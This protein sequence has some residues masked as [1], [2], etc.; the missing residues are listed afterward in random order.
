MQKEVETVDITD[1]PELLRLAEEVQQS[2][3]PRLLTRGQEELALLSPVEPH[4]KPAKPPRR[5]GSAVSSNNDWL[6][7]LAE[8]TADAAPPADGA[9]NVSSHT[10]RYLGE[11]YSDLHLPKEQ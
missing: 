10:D 9:T 8:I 6:L 7:R 3:Q 2:Q 4:P 11:A 1:I 5:S